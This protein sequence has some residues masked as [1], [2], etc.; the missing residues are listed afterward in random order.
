MV[1]SKA[2]QYSY[3]LMD[4]E[5]KAVM[6]I[7][8]K[9][10]SPPDGELFDNMIGQFKARYPELGGADAEEEKAAPDADLE[11]MDLKTLELEMAKRKR[12]K[13]LKASG[14]S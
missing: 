6:T 10:S 13:M 5:S 2:G 14:R 11:K 12:L 9:S 7:N 1:T 8:I 4:P 3:T